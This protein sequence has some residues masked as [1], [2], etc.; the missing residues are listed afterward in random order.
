MI[1]IDI[2]LHIPVLDTQKTSA[3]IKFFRI[4]KSMNFR[5]KKDLSLDKNDL[6]I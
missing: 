1:N 6:S 3:L 4:N 5:D 2:N